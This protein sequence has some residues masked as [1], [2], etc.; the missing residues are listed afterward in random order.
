MTRVLVTGAGGYIG[1]TLVP[2]LLSQNYEIIAVDRF[3]FGKDKLIG[4]PNLTVICE[5]TRRL[6]AAHFDNVDAVI[7]LAAISNDPSAEQFSRQTR[8][9]NSVGRIRT[10]KL[11][12]TSNVPRYIL[13]SSAAVYGSSDGPASEEAPTSPQTVYAEANLEAEEGVLPLASTAFSVTV[14]RQATLY[15]LSPRM[16]FDLAVNGMTFGAWKKR[17]LPLMRDGSQHRPMLHVQDTTDLMIHL[18]T[19]RT[20]LIN[21]ERFNIGSNEAN[22]KL[23]DLGNT[24]AKAVEEKTGESVEIEWYGDPDQ[25]NYILDCSRLNAKLGWTTTRTVSEG[26]GEMLDALMDGNIDKDDITI[27][28]KWYRELTR[29]HRI[30]KEVEMYG[31]ILDIE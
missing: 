16:R 29:W 1:S 10:A 3:F 9:I 28:L 18:L 25:R 5:D 12:A 15:G 24:V 23:S 30:I 19:V 8:E 11:A 14:I 27:T 7:D 31:G 26:V 21:G 22:Y 2:K 13:A 4:H 17:R 6:K 20:D